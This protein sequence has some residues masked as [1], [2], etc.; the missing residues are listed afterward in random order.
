M[1]WFS[2][3]NGIMHLGTCR[4]SKKGI[5]RCRYSLQKNCTTSKNIKA[6]KTVV[7]DGVYDF[8]I[9]SCLVV[10]LANFVQ[11]VLGPWVLCSC[12]AQEVGRKGKINVNQIFFFSLLNILIHLVFFSPRTLSRLC[13]E[14]W[15]SPW[16]FNA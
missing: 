7:L 11:S 6:T 8:N 10:S 5:L 12:G 1:K 9:C 14:W 15:H 16:V 13:I 3:K 2:G 4:F